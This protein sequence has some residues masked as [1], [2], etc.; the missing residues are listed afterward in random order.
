DKK[1]MSEALRHLGIA[2]HYAG[3][4]DTARER[5]E[6]S[7]QLRRD[8]GLLAGVAANQVG[9][10][11]IAAQQGH[12]DE[13]MALLDEAAAIAEADGAHAITRQ[14]DEARADL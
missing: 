13:A 7:V 1:T 2:A 8:M 6:E 10:A 5:L 11:Y 4:L 9:L 3:Q 12:R 14:V